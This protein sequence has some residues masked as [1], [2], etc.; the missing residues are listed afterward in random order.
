MKEMTNEELLEVS[1]GAKAALWLIISGLVV[2]AIGI[3]D[4]YRNPKACNNK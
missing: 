4:G 2:F 1:G 3:I